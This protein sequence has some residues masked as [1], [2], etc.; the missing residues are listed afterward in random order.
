MVSGT[1]DP[2]T[3][4]ERSEGAKGVRVAEPPPAASEATPHK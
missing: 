4:A 3:A 1:P 2:T